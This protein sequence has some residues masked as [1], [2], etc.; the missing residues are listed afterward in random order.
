MLYTAFTVE[1]RMARLSSLSGFGVSALGLAAVASLASAGLPLEAAP[2][3]LAS[4]GL[5]S[6]FDSA[7]AEGVAAAVVSPDCAA[8]FA[9]VFAPAGAVMPLPP[10]DSPAGFPAVSSAF[11]SGKAAALP[12]VGVP[13]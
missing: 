13:C 8:G 6:D 12:G 9:S 10:F 5:A 4:A 11:L 7:G 3:G 2:A 1:A